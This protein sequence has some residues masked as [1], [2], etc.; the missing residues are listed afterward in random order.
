MDF[1]NLHSVPIF[2]RYIPFFPPDMSTTSTVTALVV[3][4]HTLGNEA[5]LLNCMC[6]LLLA[7]GNGTPFNATSMQEE[8]IIELCVE[9][10]QTHPKGML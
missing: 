4:D 2:A 1:S 10:G 8:D 5:E 3:H 7:K 6:T 9:V